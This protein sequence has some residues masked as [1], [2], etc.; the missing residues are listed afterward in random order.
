MNAFYLFSINRI[1]VFIQPW[2][3]LLLAF[4][5]FGQDLLTGVIF[6][7]CVTVSLLVHEFGHATFAARYRLNPKVVL[8]GWGGLC[9]HDRA[10]KDSHDAL[11]IAAGP[12]AGFVLGFAC[13]GAYF[14]FP[15]FIA[16]RPM[17]NQIV[18]TLVFINI[19]W[20]IFNILP[21][22]PLDG[23]QLARLGALRI[24]RPV[25]AERIV[26]ATAICIA[27]LCAL[28]AGL[29]LREGF[30]V[31]VCLLLGYE[32]IK[33]LKTNRPAGAIRNRHTHSHKLL[34]K[35]W[36]ALEL[37][38]YT[39]AAR[40]GHQIRSEPNLTERLDGQAWEIITLATLLEGKLEDGLRYAKHAPETPRIIAARINAH[41]IQGEL[42]A[43]RHLSKTAA[44]R[45][46]PIKVRQELAR[47]FERVSD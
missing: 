18:T 33:Y 35:A 17:L 4:F 40:I 37:S 36:Q 22:W 24:F 32:N 2:Y 21:L 34:E 29:V 47:R 43:A 14:L 42:L 19:F 16:T 7:G 13:L 6:A 11:I 38:H 1:P 41:L 31:L 8:H 28:F 20:S 26:H 46:L 9:A 39:E 23:G 45:K 30:M 44:F 25:L 15:E 3:L 10:A 27:I 5:S 12:A